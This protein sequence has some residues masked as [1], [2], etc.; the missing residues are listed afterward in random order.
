[1][2]NIELIKELRELTS[3]GMSN[4]KKALEESNWDLEKAVD[5]I[6]IKGQS[7][8]ANTTSKL[9]TE[10]VVLTSFL[11]STQAMGMV[12]VN[13]NT[14]FVAKSEEFNKFVLNTLGSMSAYRLFDFTWSPT[15]PD[16]EKERLELSAKTKENI[17]VRRWWIEEAFDSNAKI[18]SY[19]HTNKKIGVMLTMLAPSEDAAKSPLFES[20]G[21]D[22]SMQIAAMSPV[23]VSSDKIS[24]DDLNRQKAIFET[25]V[26]ELNK[27]EAAAQKIIEG[28]LNKWYTEVC[29]LDQES[30]LVAKTSIRKV[31]EDIGK[32]LGGE[33][34]VV[35][36]VRCEVGQGLQKKEDNFA[37]EA[38]QMAGL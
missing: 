2:S 30:V 21:S 5:L 14:D 36:F 18:F 31:I 16:V 6:K 7:V 10:G 19:V 13:C 9:A 26:K 38:A 17:V 8:A 29:L 37:E 33:I 3:A 25:Q 12:E 28:K 11:N 23:A 24:V 4:C 35:N 1:M 20:L 15:N 27:P 34:K 32:Q 22:L